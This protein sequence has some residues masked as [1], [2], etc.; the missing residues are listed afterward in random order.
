MTAKKLLLFAFSL[1]AALC[2]SAAF[3]DNNTKRGDVI[4][5][6]FNPFPDTPVTAESLKEGGVH[7][8]YVENA[9]SELDASVT[10][11]YEA[12]SAANNEIMA[13]LHTDT[14]SESDLW[15]DLRLRKDVKGASLNYIKR[16]GFNRSGRGGK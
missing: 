9:A 4:A 1:C 10:T 8:T 3:A 16:V 2:A 5:T 12:L 11:I 7:R 6:F 15:L 13:L 14:R